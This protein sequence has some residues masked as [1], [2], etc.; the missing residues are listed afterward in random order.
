MQV[1]ESRFFLDRVGQLALNLT[2]LEIVV[3]ETH[4]R[5]DCSQILILAGVEVGTSN[6][7]NINENS[8]GGHFQA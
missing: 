8:E 7:L 1:G 6:S 5:S 3:K 2:K 4:Y